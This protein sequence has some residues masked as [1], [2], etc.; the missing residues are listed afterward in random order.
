MKKANVME[1]A[2]TAIKI[3]KPQSMSGDSMYHQ[4]INQSE[5]GNLYR[6]GIKVKMTREKEKSARVSDKGYKSRSESL[7]VCL[8]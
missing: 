6:C 8:Q 7:R 4:S 3:H 1:K 2:K 5:T